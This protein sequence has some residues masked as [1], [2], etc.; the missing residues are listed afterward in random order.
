VSTGTPAQQ[1]RTGVALGHGLRLGGDLVDPAVGVQP[2]MAVRVDQTGDDPAAVDH[3]LGAVDGLVAQQA[4][5][6]DPQ[7]ALLAVRQHDGP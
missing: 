3:R 5:G 6:V 4:L 2:D 1:Q 7:G